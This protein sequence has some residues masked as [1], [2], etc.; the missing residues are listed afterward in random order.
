MYLLLEK[1]KIIKQ[2]VKQDPKNSEWAE[3]GRD[4]FDFGLLA[5]KRFGKGGSEAKKI[6]FKTVGSNPILLDQKL[7]FQLRY[8]FFKYKEGINKTKEE[9]RQFVPENG[10]QNQSNLKN[11]LKSSLWC[12]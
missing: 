3:I 5:S 2:L 1:E 4:S 9:I 6:I 11:F 12:G 8:L 10:L 7:E